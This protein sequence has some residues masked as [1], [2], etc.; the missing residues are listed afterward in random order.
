[1]NIARRSS[2]RRQLFA[3]F[4]AIA[5]RS[6]ASTAHLLGSISHAGR[7]CMI[8]DTAVCLCSPQFVVEKWAHIASKENRLL[9]FKTAAANTSV[10]DY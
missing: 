6:S 3:I 4:S 5:D 2:A 7:R 8:R 10:R 1:M 9:F